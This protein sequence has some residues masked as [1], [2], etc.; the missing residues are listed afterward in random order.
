MCTILRDTRE[1]DES[2][3]VIQL[4]YPRLMSIRSKIEHATS[5]GDQDTFKGLTRL[6]AE[7]GEYWVVMI[8]RLPAEFRGLVEAIL[9]CCARDTDR[10][11]ISLTFLFWYEFKQIIVMERYQQARNA[12]TGVWSN[13]MDIMIKH[14]EY[15]MPEDPNEMDLFAGD[16]EQEE[17]FRAF[18]HQMGDVLKDCCDV[19][20]VTECLSKASNLIRLWISTHGSQA[21]ESKVPQ[22]QQLEAPIFSMRAMGRMVSPEESEVL[23]QVI[24]LIVQ[25]PNH[26][27]LRFQAIMALGRYTDWTSQH[28]EFLQPQLNFVIAGFKHQSTEVVKAA[29][30]AFRFF[31]TDCRQL[32]TDHVTQLHD[33]YESVLDTLVP[34]SQ[35]E[36]TEGV[37]AVVSA[38]P[39][40]KIYPMFK[41]YCD[42]II[43][44]MMTRANQAQSTVDDSAGLAV[45]GRNGLAEISWESLTRVVDYIQLLTIFIQNVQPYVPPSA[46]NPA[47]RYCQE[48]LPVMS[49]IAENFTSSTPIL[50]RVCRCW[51][52]MVLSYRTAILPLLPT[53]AQQLASGFKNSRQGCFL[54]ATDSVLREFADGAEFVDVA[55]SQAIYNFFE[56]QA[57]AFLR[58]MNDL[59]PSD[60]PDVIEDFFRLLI[61]ALIYY[62]GSLLPAP[63]CS[64][65]LSAAISAL[66]LQQE[67]PLT[68]TLHFLCDFLSYGT[69]HPNSSSFQNGSNTARVITPPELQ[70]C[71]TRLI[72]EQ[73]EMLT[74]RIL[75]GMMFSFPRDCLQDASS[76]LLA[77]LNINTQAVVQWVK[78][79]VDMLPTGTLKQGEGEKL[80][81]GMATKIQQGELRKVK[82]LLQDFTTSYRRRNV[83]PR[84]GLGRLEATR[85]R[86]S[87]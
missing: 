66:I 42:P 75:T 85:F 8:A 15:P 10:E 26:E 78:N 60:L 35:E 29:A 58:I 31:G 30:L 11:A 52:Y 74:Q 27:K 14:L 5:S 53:L 38:Q 20:T 32:L 87:G 55:T 34:A 33:F 84:E 54:W 24:P 73:G 63:V 6:Y 61:D 40:D 17:K 21:T 12:F 67:A 48:I 47:V 65:I 81:N 79:T 7:A 72:S 76:V 51:R 19:I 86:F 71:V 50:E 68:A 46:E 37:A 25:I 62:H 49:T 1:V 57:L 18:R 36:V 56:Q 77:M 69:D 2:I 59:P 3:E 4:I 23:H 43:K 9:E 28:P 45:A 44:R 16:R 13:L 22:W 83:A 70:Q 82:V 39:V 64:P 41:L 80:L